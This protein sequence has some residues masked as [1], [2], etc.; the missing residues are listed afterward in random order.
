M[1]ILREVPYNS[2]ILFIESVLLFSKSI[3]QYSIDGASSRNR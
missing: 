2:V 3:E 1:K